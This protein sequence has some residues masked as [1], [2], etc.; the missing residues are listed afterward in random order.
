MSQNVQGLKIYSWFFGFKSC[1][2]FVAFSANPGP[3]GRSHGT[4]G[5][6]L[7]ERAHCRLPQAPTTAPKRCKFSVWHNAKDGCATTTETVAACACA[8]GA[9]ATRA[10]PAAT[11]HTGTECLPAERWGRLSLSAQLSLCCCLIVRVLF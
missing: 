3:P 4:C 1:M 11:V 2:I 5:S 10:V 9:T 8:G 7:G 6:T